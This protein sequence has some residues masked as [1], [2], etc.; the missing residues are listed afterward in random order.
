MPRTKSSTTP[1]DQ[2]LKEAR[3]LSPPTPWTAAKRVAAAASETFD[4]ILMD[5][6]MRERDGLEA[7]GR[8]RVWKLR[9]DTA[10]RV[11]R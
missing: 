5:V 1:C 4:L 8:I 11:S 7:T 9:W 10:R 2:H 3:A 6:Q